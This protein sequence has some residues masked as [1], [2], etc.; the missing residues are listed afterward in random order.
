MTSD[1]NQYKKAIEAMGR[2]GQLFLPYS[3]CPRGQVGRAGCITLPEEALLMD[4]VTDVDGNQW[5]PV[6]E[7]VLQDLLKQLD[8]YKDKVF[9]LCYQRALQKLEEEDSRGETQ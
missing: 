8:F 5:R 9:Q 7:E 3:G 1:N 6:N 4:P 2:F